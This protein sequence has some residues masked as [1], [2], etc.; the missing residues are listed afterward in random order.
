MADATTIPFGNG[1]KVRF[2]F[3]DSTDGDFSPNVY[4]AELRE[5]QDAVVSGRWSWVHQVHGAT[6]LTVSDEPVQG[7]SADALVTNRPQMPIS[8]RVADCA[9]VLLW[10]ETGDSVVVSA[11]HAGWKGLVA[12]VLE[13]AVAR[14]R[15]LGAQR[16]RWVLGP[17][18]SAAHYE[19]GEADLVTMADLFGPQVRGVTAD[20]RPALDIGAAVRSA[21]ATGGVV[22]FH[23]RSDPVCTAASPNHFSY[24]R[25][26]D[27]QRQVGVIWW[28]PPAVS[29]P[30]QSGVTR[31]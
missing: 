4:P 17:R 12:G 23:N 16:I 30:G 28:E 26:G 6:A 1:A 2:V 15:T 22:P 10:S 5:R 7:C 3:T 18:I 20:G 11:V 31:E 13:A 24:R 14:M 29:A 19:F 9:P 27:S 8:V 25:S 21:L